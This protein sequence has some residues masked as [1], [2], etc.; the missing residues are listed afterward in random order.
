MAFVGLEKAPFPLYYIVGN[1]WETP[2]T[3]SQGQGVSS[4]TGPLSGDVT[5][6]GSAESWLRLLW[7]D[8][9]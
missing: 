8:R 6:A 2:Q 7:L 4:A 9:P 3:W 1:P 5:E